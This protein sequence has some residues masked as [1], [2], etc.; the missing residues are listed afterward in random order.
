MES[1][2][3]ILFFFGIL[4]AL[5][6]GIVGVQTVALSIEQNKNLLCQP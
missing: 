4:L 3:R 1:L 6:F 5:T 2:G